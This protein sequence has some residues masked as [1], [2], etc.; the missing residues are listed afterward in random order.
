[1]TREYKIIIESLSGN[2][3][4]HLVVLGYSGRK[5]NTHMWSCKCRCGKIITVTQ[6]SIKSGKKTSCGCNG[7]GVWYEE[8][9]K[10]VKKDLVGK[11]FGKLTVVGY[12]GTTQGKSPKNLWDCKCE[13]GNTVIVLGLSLIGGFTKSCGCIRIKNSDTYNVLQNYK[14]GAKKRGYT[15]NLSKELEETLIQSNC[16][17]CGSPPANHY[18]GRTYMGID[19]IDNSRGYEPDNVVP[20]CTTCNFAKRKMSVEEFKHW[21]FSV[22]DHLNARNIKAYR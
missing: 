7:L 13:C 17:Y 4:G 19:R 10:T 11:S 20:C 1:M 22:F 8:Y 12:K 14:N 15:Y 18:L 21:I 16:Y 5:R 2:T 3:Y 9:G 6:T